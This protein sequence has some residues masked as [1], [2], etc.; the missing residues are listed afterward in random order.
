MKNI[1]TVKGETRV[2]MFLITFGF[3]YFTKGWLDLF[4]RNSNLKILQLS[5][6]LTIGDVLYD[7]IAWLFKK[8]KQKI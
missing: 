5:F 3:F 2:I 1:L 6:I 7:L 8:N 4:E